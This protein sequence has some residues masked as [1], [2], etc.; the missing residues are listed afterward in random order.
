MYI[1]V[2]AYIYTYTFMYQ[3][4][5]MHTYLY[6]L[7]PSRSRSIS[8]HSAGW[9]SILKSQHAM[10]HT[11]SNHSRADWNKLHKIKNILHQIIQYT[12]SNHYSLQHLERHFFNLKSQSR[13]FFSRSLSPRSVE[14]RPM[15]LRME[16]EIQWYSKC[17]WLHMHMK[18]FMY[19]RKYTTWNHWI[20]HIKSL[21]EVITYGVE[22][23][24]MVYTMNH[25]I[26]HIK[27]LHPWNHSTYNQT[28]STWNQKIQYTTC[29]HEVHYT[30]SF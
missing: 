11:I 21:H 12:T 15:R 22:S 2:F 23:L 9:D 19:N 28:H 27:S 6:Y 20:H 26:H 1:Y 16:I 25:W 8:R 30:K 17:N 29:N 18:S 3:Y 5:Y 24:H 10:K 13:I 7:P 4:I 14:K